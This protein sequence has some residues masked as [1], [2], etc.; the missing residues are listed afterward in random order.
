MMT[1]KQYFLNKLAEECA[2][3]A[4]RAIKQTQFGKDETQASG[5]SETKTG[6]AAE[7]NNVRLRGELIDL[8]TVVDI[9]TEMGEIPAIGCLEMELRKQE[10]RKKLFKYLAYSQSLGQVTLSVEERKCSICDLPLSKCAARS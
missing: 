6:A 8:L 1:V 5:P 2:E 3:V 7:T 4:Q 9:L 10:K